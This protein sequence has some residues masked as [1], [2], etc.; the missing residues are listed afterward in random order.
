MGTVPPEHAAAV[1]EANASLGEVAIERLQR[2]GQIVWMEEGFFNGSPTR[3]VQ[4]FGDAWRTLWT[5]R[6][7][8][9]EQWLVHASGLALTPVYGVVDDDGFE[10]WTLYTQAGDVMELDCDMR[11]RLG[12]R[13]WQRVHDQ[14]WK[15]C[16]E[17]GYVRGAAAP[18]GTPS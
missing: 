13:A 1:A 7:Q 9:S 5:I 4:P 11:R 3:L 18:A 17:M 16:V 2:E 8:E 14:G 10:A 12:E 6:E 15:L